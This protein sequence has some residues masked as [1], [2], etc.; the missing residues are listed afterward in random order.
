VT[1]ILPQEVTCPT[2]GAAF[3]AFDVT[4]VFFTGDPEIDRRE[5]EMIEAITA[6]GCP[7]C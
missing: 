1:T 2:C 7:R 5:I 6:N 4:S 3:T